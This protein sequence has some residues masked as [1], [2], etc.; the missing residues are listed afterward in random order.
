MSTIAALLI[1]QINYH[2]VVSPHYQ[3]HSTNSKKGCHTRYKVQPLITNKWA[4][5]D[6]LTHQ[7][8]QIERNP[9]PSRG[10]FLWVTFASCSILLNWFVLGF[11]R[12][13]LFARLVLHWCVYM[14]TMSVT[15]IYVVE[16]AFLFQI[17]GHFTFLIDGW[18]LCGI[19]PVLRLFTE[20]VRQ[21]AGRS[22]VEKEQ[23]AWSCL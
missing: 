17:T 8:K 9:A 12:T 1:N 22:A 23:K 20:A 2:Q 5:K 10:F 6:S 19:H 4:L 16:C 7:K 14:L 13:W 15:V 3:R 21:A 11:Y 18:N